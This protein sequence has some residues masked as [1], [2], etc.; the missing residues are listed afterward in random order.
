MFFISSIEGK[1]VINEDVL[2]KIN[3]DGDETSLTISPEGDKIIFT[4]KNPGENIFNL[5]IIN[6]NN[7]SWS[8]PVLLENLNSDH[9]DI[10]PFFADNGKRLLFASN[11]Q[12]SLNYSGTDTP[13]YDIYYSE[14]ENN[15]WTKPVQLFG[16][17]NTREDEINPFITNGGNT[18]YF[19]RINSENRENSKIIKV[20][21]AD[22]FWSDVTTAPIS[23]QIEIKPFF[24][25]P[26]LTGEALYFSGYIETPEKKDIYY[27]K[28]NSEDET[29][30]LIAGEK[31]N[32][33][34][35]EIFACPLGSKRLLV[36]T[37]HGEMGNYN[38]IIVPAV[39]QLA[40]DRA[41]NMEDESRDKSV[42]FNFNSSVIKLEY[43]PR[44]H[45]VLTHLRNNID[46]RLI[47]HGYAD[48]V[49]SHKAN[50]DISLRRAE[51]AKAYLVKMGI[52]SSRIETEGH[53]YIKTELKHTAQYHRRVDFE[54]KE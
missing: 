53:G 33:P 16:A 34:D 39:D 38:F 42:Y 49:G 7:E 22:D 48:G 2:S 45:I 5:H 4:R 50:I 1:P 9:N 46:S 37:N 23:S 40:A 12:R 26:S 36:S 30:I 32:S 13:S 25:R 14:L 21:K 31:I 24:V 41:E 43:I 17:V 8:D 52:E 27:S 18:L 6:Y 35:D 10:S 15:E 47:I 3:S 28:I 51:S 11:R 20:E 19:T 54:F 44:L 29:E